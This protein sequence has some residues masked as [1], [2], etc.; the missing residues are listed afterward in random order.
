M[1]KPLQANMADLRGPPSALQA[2]RVL[3]DTSSCKYAVVKQVADEAGMG[4][5]TENNEWHIWWTDTSINH[6]RAAALSL[7]QRVNHFVDMTLICRKASAAALLNRNARYSPLEFSF[8]PRSWQLPKDLAALT[9]AMKSASPPVIIVK[10]DKGSQGAGIS[11]CRTLAE[12]E[13]TRHAASLQGSMLQGVAQE[14]LD[15]PLLLDG[16]KFDLRLYVLVTSCTPLRVH[17]YR[18]GMARLCTEKYHPTADGTERQPLSAAAGVAAAKSAS[19]WRKRHLT[20]YAIN[21]HHHGYAS[22]ECGAKRR[23]G[24]L[25]DTLSNEHGIHTDGLWGQI[26]QLV[27]KTLL[28][29]QPQ[30]A[31]AYSSCRPS[32]DAHPF[33]CFELLGFDLLLDCNVTAM[34]PSPDCT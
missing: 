28:T 32:S 17:L 21:R 9:K 4:A 5:T 19:D 18:D 34:G 26:E 20:N 12:L 13:A 25:F 15:A 11:I 3:V 6:E 1:G 33:S 16:H 24:D 7:L 22:G 30:L 10:P 8:V 31:H 27:V 2:S 23:L 29:V 14:Y